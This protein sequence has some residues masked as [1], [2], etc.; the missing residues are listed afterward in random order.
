M[1]NTTWTLGELKIWLSKSILE[2]SKLRHNTD[3]NNDEYIR[4]KEKESTLKMVLGKISEL[5]NE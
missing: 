2:V 3:I 4:L 1:N 5:E